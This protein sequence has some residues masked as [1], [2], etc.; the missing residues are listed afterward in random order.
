L[1]YALVK[2]GAFTIVSQLGGSGEKLVSLDDYA[3][4]GQR[5]PW[6]AASLSVFL[7]SLLGLPVTAGFFGKF[8]IFTAAVH[9]KLIWLAILM[10]V[11]SVIGSYYYLHFI[12]IMYMHEPKPGTTVAPVRFPLTAR[13]VLLVTVAGTLYFGLAPTR[14]LNFLNQP[15]SSAPSSNRGNADLLI[16]SFLRRLCGTAIPVYPGR[17]CALATSHR[18]LMLD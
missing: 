16:A 6:V 2:V 8:Y 17:G 3:G 10:A 1:S 15:T 12:I 7:L 9:S 11:N 14:A 18:R 4:L 13:I 5:Q